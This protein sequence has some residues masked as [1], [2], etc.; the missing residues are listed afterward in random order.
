MR[1]AANTSGTWTRERAAALRRRGSDPLRGRI[2]PLSRGSGGTITAR[3]RIDEEKNM[4][5]GGLEPD[6]DARQG[7]IFQGSSSADIRSRS[8]NGSIDPKAGRLA[9]GVKLTS[10]DVP[11]RASR[12]AGRPRYGAGPRRDGEAPRRE[13]S[14]SPSSAATVP[15]RSRTGFGEGS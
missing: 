6:G 5:G 8:L 11:A 4:R 9:G 7:W 2:V 12:R 10:D 1:A 15:A 3:G 13:A 14:G